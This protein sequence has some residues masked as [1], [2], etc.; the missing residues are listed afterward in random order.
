MRSAGAKLALLMAGMTALPAWAVPQ[1]R[2]NFTGGAVCRVP[3]P[4][5]LGS[6]NIGIAIGLMGPNPKGIAP[7]WSG[8]RIE[9]GC[10]ARTARD[11]GGET[12][13]NS[14][15]GLSMLPG[16]GPSGRVTASWWTWTRG[17]H[18]RGGFGSHSDHTS[19]TR[20]SGTGRLEVTGIGDPEL[21][22]LW[23]RASFALPYTSNGSSFTV[24]ADIPALDG[25]WGVANQQ[26]R[27]G[28]YA[29]D[30][31]ILSAQGHSINFSF[32]QN[33]AHGGACCTT[34]TD[35]Q[36]I[37]ID[38]EIISPELCSKADGGHA[39]PNSTDLREALRGVVCMNLVTDWSRRGI[40]IYP[41][42]SALESVRK[43]VEAPLLQ[44]VATIRLRRFWSQAEQQVGRLLREGAVNLR[45][46]GLWLVSPESSGLNDFLDRV[47]SA[48][49][50]LKERREIADEAV[51]LLRNRTTREGNAILDLLAESLHAPT[52]LTDEGI[53]EARLAALAL[54]YDTLDEAMLVGQEGDHFRAA[55]Q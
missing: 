32:F 34:R 8:E 7:M 25:Q 54:G 26:T 46:L 52:Y 55:N 5:P 36:R 48:S 21:T 49:L 24:G 50:D 47:R 30:G 22:F 16:S 6:L 39:N 38:Y 31:A 1:L 41:R 12:D 44:R 53:E 40:E 14:E 42:I 4:G 11:G 10:G 15:A 23:G 37:D 19:L 45:T 3:S 18:S 27:H 35:G 17:G 2:T 20:I 43:N 28:P 51:G 9:N 33:Q 13:S 29:L